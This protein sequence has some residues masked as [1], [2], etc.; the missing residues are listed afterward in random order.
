MRNIIFIIDSNIVGVYCGY[1]KTTR[2]DTM[3]YELEIELPIGNG[4]CDDTE[5]VDMCID[6]DV[7]TIKA[8]PDV[9]VNHD[10]IEITNYTIPTKY[11]DDKSVIEQVESCLEYV[12]TKFNESM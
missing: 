3:E 4:D 7:E 6:F 11:K 12:E 1:R 2:S 9:G 10:Y 8:Q 5:I